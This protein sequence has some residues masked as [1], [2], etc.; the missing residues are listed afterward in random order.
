MGILLNF[1]PPPDLPS[2]K[3]WQE[4]L[5]RVGDEYVRRLYQAARQSTRHSPKWQRHLVL[6]DE[7]MRRRNIE[8]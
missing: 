8:T 5:S 3:L 6:A 4:M 1:C 7:A 2:L